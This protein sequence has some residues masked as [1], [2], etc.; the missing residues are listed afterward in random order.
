[1]MQTIALRTTTR[2]RGPRPVAPLAWTALVLVGLLAAPF[3]AARAQETHDGLKDGLPWTIKDPFAVLSSDTIARG[4]RGASFAAPP[5]LSPLSPGQRPT[6]S[7]DVRRPDAPR[8][9]DQDAEARLAWIYW[10]ARAMSGGGDHAGAA[11]ALAAMAPHA[12]G[13]ARDLHLDAAEAFAKAGDPASSQA[14]LALSGGASSPL[15]RARIGARLA[16]LDDRWPEALLASKALFDDDD[17]A[18][19][20][21]GCA[22]ALLLLKAAPAAALEPALGRPGVT[23]IL[24]RL[25]V[26]CAND[27]RGAEID[28]AFKA[29]TARIG[30]SA[31][32][33]VAPGPREILI[34]ANLHMALAENK[35]AHDLLAGLLKGK[36]LDPAMA[37]EVPFWMARALKAMKRNGETRRYY[38]QAMGACT[39]EV[40]ARSEALR[41]LRTRAHHWT[42]D[43][44][45][46][47]RDLKTARAAF[48]AIAAEVPDARHADD[49]IY[50]LREIALAE[51][52]DKDAAALM[53]RLLGD[54]PLGD[55]TREAVWA[56]IFEDLK[57]R[58]W[59]AAR[60]RL[61]VA[62]EMPPD[63]TYYSQGRH[64]YYLGYVD[65]VLGDD[66]A[67]ARHWARCFSEN[68]SAFYGHLCAQSLMTTS[69]GRAYVAGLSRPMRA[70]PVPFEVRDPAL[71][72]FI[73]LGDFGRASALVLS[74]PSPSP[75]DLWL[76]AWL[77]H[78][79]G[80]PTLAHNIARRRVP[81]WP[82]R[83]GMPTARTRLLW[84]IAFPDPYK[85][86]QDRWSEERG[87]DP[88]LVRAITREESGFEP[89][90][91]SWAGAVG[92]MQLIL[93]TA[94][95]N[96]QG[97]GVEITQ[98][99][100]MRP[101]IN[102]PIATRF[103]RQLVDEFGAHPLLVACG[104]NAGPGAPQK[105][106]KERGGWNTGLFAEATPYEEARN[107]SRRVTGSH[108]IYQWLYKADVAPG[109]PPLARWSV[110]I[111]R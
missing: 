17:P 30:A 6:P 48:E 106:I 24:R 42:G 63:P 83:Y 38:E 44:A 104:Y 2:R 29:L 49:A 22:L 96:A 61:L 14:H 107:Y 18:P 85:A 27:A 60:E 34:R 70:E 82:E 103:L 47:E 95:G 90:L 11:V 4:P 23:E 93:P 68:P 72:G 102:I 26:V 53:A 37:C 88:A 78:L 110:T 87:V 92:L 10:Q 100:L 109:E 86:L 69:G 15:Q 97:V 50:N 81:G 99:S 59:L 55:M 31:A 66:D 9:A 32:R 74:A 65:S 73:L 1:M 91:V 80:Q 64:R 20:A 16:L 94:R 13:I 84:E 54:Y 12:G 41:V 77:A 39:L 76:G 67:A 57:Q 71:R 28:V 33:R 56:P 108:G 45:L 58:R 75:H 51:G 101:E 8:P 52:R 111:P 19:D 62:V 43:R 40:A 36:A 3:P 21:E 98:Q 5:D 105:W 35:E 79:D 25:G 46:R 89:R 7:L